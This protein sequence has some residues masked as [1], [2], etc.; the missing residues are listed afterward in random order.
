[1]Q[2]ILLLSFI[3]LVSSKLQCTS[4]ESLPAKNEDCFNRAVENED[5]Y[6]C[7]GEFKVSIIKFSTCFESPKSANPEFMMKLLESKYKESNVTVYN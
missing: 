4:Q 3:Y 2:K 1:M 5:S 6:C 7:F